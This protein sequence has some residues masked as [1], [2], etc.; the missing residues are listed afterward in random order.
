[1]LDTAE[2]TH[3]GGDSGPAVVPGDLDASLLIKA[4]RYSDPDF[5]MPPSGKLSASEIE[6][7][8]KWV[9]D[10][11]FDPR[12]AGSTSKVSEGAGRGMS[13]ADG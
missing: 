6:V 4:I 12:T 10:G 13:I 5:A 1:M 8:E 2:A 11:A 3:E 7:L 9:T